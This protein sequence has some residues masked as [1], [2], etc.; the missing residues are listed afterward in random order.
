[1]RQTLFIKTAIAALLSTGLSEITI[2][3]DTEKERCSGIVTAG[4]NDCSTKGH[5]CAGQA[6]EDYDPDEWIY[7]TKGT[8]KKIAGGVILEG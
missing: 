1:M 8:C 3:E 2:A 7:V 5:S 6:K 4:M